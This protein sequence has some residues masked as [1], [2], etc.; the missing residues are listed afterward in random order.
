MSQLSHPARHATHPTRH[1]AAPV[2]AVTLV[3][4][5]ACG[6]SGTQRTTDTA[7]AVATATPAMVPSGAAPGAVPA[8]AADTADTT[9][10]TP[11]QRF[12]RNMSNHHQGLIQMAH[13]VMEDRKSPGV[14][15][16]AQ[17]LDRAQDAELDTMRTMLQTRFREQ[18][19]PTVLPQ[20][21][22]M[23]DSL[24][25]V[26]GTGVPFDTTFLHLIIAHHREA[27]RM[28]NQALPTLTDARLRT[29]AERMRRDQT[30]EIAQ[31]ER[32][33]RTMAHR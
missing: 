20:N 8:T 16:D 12:L 23:F 6:G 1:R 21:Q 7:G 5:M 29:M 18:Y 31:F 25:A 28:V 27:V 13:Y 19:T 30:R 4:T 9:R 14:L 24:R 10:M 15:A 32:Q 17:K 26:P 3:A 33:K 22:A 11:D 2:L